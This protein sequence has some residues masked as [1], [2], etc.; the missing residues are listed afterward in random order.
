MGHGQQ[1]GL[2]RAPEAA[3][4]QPARRGRARRRGRLLQALPALLALAFMAAAPAPRPVFA[5]PV[6][7]KAE[8]AGGEREAPEACPPENRLD[9]RGPWGQARFTVEIADDPA[10]RARGLMHRKALPRMSGMLFVYESPRPVAFWM[11][12]TLIPLDMI[13]ADEAGRVVRVH[14]MARPLDETPIPGGDSIRFVLELN[15]GMAA[16]LGIGPSSEMRHRA[17]DPALAAWP[18]A[19]P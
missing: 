11:K 17:I 9:L 14:E 19:A 16:A 4:A 8:I 12:N 1:E 18:C 6:S 13:F 2:R 7:P 3:T 5:Q 15:G 10:E